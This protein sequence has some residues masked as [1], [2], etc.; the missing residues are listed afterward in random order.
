M[1]V[2]LNLE[3]TE[4]QALAY[5]TERIQGGKPIAQHPLIRAKLFDMFMSIEAGRA[6]GRAAMIYN[7]SNTP[8]AL[9]YSIASKVFCTQ[10]AFRCASEGVQILGGNGLSR[11]YIMEKLFRDTR[12][13]LIGDGTSEILAQTAAEKFIASYAAR[14]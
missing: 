10:A 14:M 5:A 6:L 11:E 1:Y 3:L 4:E 8:P 13:G 9:E 7:Y 12:A 2:E